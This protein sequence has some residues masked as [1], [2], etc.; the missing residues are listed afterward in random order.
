MAHPASPGGLDE[1]TELAVQASPGRPV[2]AVRRGVRHNTDQ[3]PDGT[4]T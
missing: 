3:L 4:W 1:M 2:S